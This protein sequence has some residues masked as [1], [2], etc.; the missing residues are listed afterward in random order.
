M[1][2]IYLITDTVTGLKY[3]GSKKDWEGPGTYFGS[4]SCKSKI[5]KKYALQKEWKKAVKERPDTFEL[6]VLESFDNIPHKELFEKE[7]KWQIKYNVNKSMEFIN[8]RY[9]TKSTLGNIYED[10]TDEE[11]DAL[12]KKV[13]EGVKRTASKMTTEERKAAWS[14]SGKNNPNYG[15]KWSDEDKNKA[16]EI[17]KQ[18][19]ASGK[20]K[21]YKLGK[22]NKELF[23]EEKAK[24]I[25]KKLSDIA[26][27]R[28]GNKNPFFGK[29]HSYETKEKLRKANLGRKSTNT[30]IVIIDNVKYKGLVEASKATGVKPT[31]IWHRIKS[32]N[33]KYKEYKY[34]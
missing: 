23:G 19:Y 1:D 9:A 6:T 30:K 8:V 27:K 11:A 31:T 17:V 20:R 33:V 16:S 26:S 25:S 14:R 28:I 5:F 15:N 18:E 3:I 24:E 13:S 29:K 7:K 22:T 10:L 2:I 34:G 21:K 32:K 4:P 12:K